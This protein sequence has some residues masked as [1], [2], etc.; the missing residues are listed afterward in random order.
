MGFYADFITFGVTDD[1]KIVPCFWRAALHWPQ[2]NEYIL[3]NKVFITIWK[4]YPSKTFPTSKDYLFLLQSPWE[5]RI[6]CSTNPGHNELTF[7]FQVTCTANFP[8][9]SLPFSLDCRFLEKGVYNFSLQLQCPTECLKP[10]THGSVSLL[11]NVIHGD[12]AKT[13]KRT[14][15]AGKILTF[16]L[17][18]T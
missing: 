14:R 5:G 2:F 12:K 4:K 13:E 16:L 3:K 1:G 6:W 18:A 8:L 17:N 11:R 10:Y 15:G 9:T 7:M